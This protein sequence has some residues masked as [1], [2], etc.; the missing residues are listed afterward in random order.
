LTK[1]TRKI[2]KYTNKK[3]YGQAH[4]GQEW[5]S[6]ADSSESES[7][8]LATITIK[9]KAS[10]SKSLFSKFSK[11]TC[12]MA[13]KGRKKIK[14]NTSSSLKY[15]TRDKDTLSNDNYDSSGDDNHL[16]SELVKN[17]NAMIKG[18]MR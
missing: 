17:P 6:S 12:L 4:V 2:K 18:L 11:H 7:D 14:S 3:P 13:K 8:D 9:G 5:N 16:P 1:A 15:V 10:S